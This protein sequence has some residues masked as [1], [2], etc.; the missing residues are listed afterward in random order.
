MKKPLSAPPV[1]AAR[2]TV[3]SHHGVDVPD[4]Y[5]WLKDANWRQVLKDPAALD[6]AIRAYLEA[7]NAY[8]EALLA[9]FAD[10]QTELFEEMRGRI[11]QDDATVPARDGAF[12][13]Y[14]RYREGGQYPLFCRRSAAGEGQEE[15][16]LDGDGIAR[17]SA[18]MQFGGVRHSS[19]HRLLA[20]GCD[21]QGSEYYAIRVRDLATGLDLADEIPN[22][23]VGAVVWT[24]DATAFYYIRLDEDHRGL[25]VFRHI[26]GTPAA[27]DEL[28]YREHDIGFFVSLSDT[29]SG[30]Y[31]EIS[32]HD[33]ETSESWL[34]DLSRADARPFLVAARQTGVQYDVEHHPSLGG[35]DR[36]IIQTNADGAEDF[37]LVTAPL[38]SPER[39]NWQD[40]VPHRAGTLLISFG[41]FRDWLM[42]L[43]R[44][45]G[46]PRIIVRALGSGEEHTIAFPEEAY[47]LGMDAGFE[48]DTDILRFTYSSMTTPDEVWDYDLRTRGRTLRKR[49]EIPSGHDPAH[50]VTRRVFAAARDGETV[51]ISLLHRRDTVLNAATPCLLFGYGSYGMAMPASFSSNRLSLVDRGFIYAIAHIRGGTEKG[52]R[53]YTQGKLAKKNNT[54]GDF[55]AAAEHLIGLG[56]TSPQT[57]VAQ[58]GSAGGMLM[59]AVANMRPDLFG[60]IIAEV[61]FVDV[62]NTMLDES[63]PLTAPEWPEWGNPITDREALAT[64]LAYSPYDNVRAQDY[65][66]LLVLAGVSDPRVFYWEP[67]KWVARLR[68]HKT[69]ANAIA[70]R[71]N[72]ESGHGGASGRFN[73]LKEVAIAYAFAIAVARG[74]WPKQG[75]V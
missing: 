47:S 3:I 61:P 24:Q 26:V 13:Y 12:A 16:L 50:Y 65:P 51:P 30:R 32:A 9:P 68:K 66:A 39:T 40:I 10:L 22:S 45:E 14:V 34:V 38:A 75:L 7:E 46:L 64:I 48:F 2:P 70:L 35:E 60:G 43:E 20:W 58:G 74:E 53:W 71:V 57:I 67:A 4:D 59:G 1:A 69:D 62:L 72:M 11:K 25:E 18:F 36:L 6:P 28:I 31:M 55:I 8:A 23:N 29:Q 17:E 44:E 63:L 54:F 33:H 15:L 42:R 19:K 73:R 37:K 41:V 21:T 27:T 49:K 5:A 56:W 52:W